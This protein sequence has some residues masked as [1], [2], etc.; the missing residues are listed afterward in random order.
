MKAMQI[1]LEI[2]VTIGVFYLLG[3]LAGVGFCK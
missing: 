2:A 3:Y 1:I